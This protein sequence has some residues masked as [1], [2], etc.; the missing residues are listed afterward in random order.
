MIYISLLEV[1]QAL[2]YLDKSCNKKWGL[3]TFWRLDHH[4]DKDN[5]TTLSGTTAQLVKINLSK[6]RADLHLCFVLGNIERNILHYSTKNKEREIDLRTYR[7]R[8]ELN[9]LNI[10]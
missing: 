10:L 6:R 7:V 8:L 9:K 5:Y 2:F 4:K 3:V 1:K